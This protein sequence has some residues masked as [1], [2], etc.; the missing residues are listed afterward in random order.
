MGH[1]LNITIDGVDYVAIP[2]NE[3]QSTTHDTD[4][5]DVVHFDRIKELLASGEEE[6]MPAEYANRILEGESPLR[7]WRE[8]RGMTLQALADCVEVSRGYISEIE[9]AH[10]DGSVR[11]MKAI[12]DT[13]SVQLD[14]IV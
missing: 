3:Y 6:L 10:K 13:L 9:N 4:T 5:M 7:V 11:V 8:Y 2:K 12:A 14:D 1:H